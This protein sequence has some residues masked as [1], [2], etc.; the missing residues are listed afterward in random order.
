MDGPTDSHIVTN[1]ETVNTSGDKDSPQNQTL[2]A[3]WSR[4]SQTPTQDAE[5]MTRE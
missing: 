1:S 2:N 5:R 3:Q 4:T